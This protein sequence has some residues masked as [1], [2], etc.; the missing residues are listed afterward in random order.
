MK[1][2]LNALVVVEGTTDVQKLMPFIDA[3]FVIT[4]GSAVSKE[5]IQFIQEAKL[6]GKDIIVLTDPDFPGEQIRHK[7]DQS[8]P[9]LTHIFLDKQQAIAKR[10]V[11]VAQAE[12][13]YLLQ[14]LKHKVTAKQ[15]L[16]PTITM[17]DLQDL[18]LVGEP[19]SSILRVKVSQHFHLG[20]ANVKTMLKRLNFLGISFHEVK[21]IL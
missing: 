14:S 18:G 5:T 2:H 10:K 6:R 7:L 19:S 12:S 15:T 20:Q 1:L 16:Q 9:G 13:A 11:G 17:H 4:N 3:E 21:S 8:I